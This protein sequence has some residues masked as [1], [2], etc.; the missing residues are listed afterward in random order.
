MAKQKASITKIK[1]RDGRIVK[2]NIKRISNVIF[3]AL[4]S[5]NKKPS[6]V[7]KLSEKIAK[8]VEAKLIKIFGGVNRIPGVEDIQD[9]VEAALLEAKEFD[10][11]KNYIE[12]RQ[13]RREVRE[14]KKELLNKDRLSPLEKR[15]SLNSIRVLASRYLLKNIHGKI[16]EDVPHMFKRVAVA[17]TLPELLYD[18]KVFKKLP[19]NKIFVQKAPAPGDGCNLK[20]TAL[21]KD[22][23]VIKFLESIKPKVRALPTESIE[24]IHS[25]YSIGSF[26]LTYAHLERLAITYDEIK[27][28]TG[29][30]K[31]SF[32]KF[33]DLLSKGYFDKY[34][35]L[36]KKF[37]KLMTSQE[38]MPNSPTLMNAGL[39][40][41]QLSAC[42]VVDIE[43]DIT[44]ILTTNLHIGLIFK[45]GGGVGANY[46]KLRPE[47][48]YVAS[49]GG[50]A[51]GPLSFMRIIDTTTDVIKQGGKRRGANM[52]ILD[53][54]HPDIEKFIMV[55]E[56]LK[57][58]TNFNLSVGMLRE[59]WDAYKKRK[60]LKLVNPHTQ[61]VTRE[62]DPEHIINTIAHSAWKSAEPG[63]LFFDNINKHNV[64]HKAKGEIKA[65]NPCGEQ[66]L[67][68]YESC[69]LG[70]INIARF[71]SEKNGKLTFNYK[72]Y[73]S[74]IKLATHML[75]NIITINK[76]PIPQIR[77]NTLA[78][79]KVGLGI[80][81]LANL[82]YML[83]IPYNSKQ[84]YDLM[85]DL[86][87]SLAYYSMEYSVELA[88]QKGAFPLY[89]KSEYPEG[90]L[91]LS[92]VYEHPKPKRDWQKLTE[93]IKKHGIRNS[94]TTTLAPT[95]SI[96]MISDTSSGLEPQFA[97][98]YKKNVAVGSFY[99]M[100]PVFEQ[101]LICK[102]Q[103][104]NDLKQIVAD[105]AGSIQTLKDYFTE[106]ERKVFVVSQDI[107][108]LDHIIA[109]F[110]WQRWNSSSISKTINMPEETTPQD[111]KQAYIIAHEIGLKGMT[112]FR[113]GSRVGVIEHLG[114]RERFKPQ[115]SFYA[116]EVLE[117]LLKNQKTIYYARKDLQEELYTLL[118][119][120]VTAYQTGE[121]NQIPLISPN[122]EEQ[123]EK[124]SPQDDKHKCPV[125]GGKVVFESGCEKCIECGWSACSV[126]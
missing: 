18:E 121:N 23:E 104:G 55:K 26:P 7:K 49:T 53:V 107:H 1:K 81:G 86:A 97:L 60:L 40:L 28:T 118:K 47:G 123:T 34:F 31:I 37:Y 101:Y 15:F 115:P 12:Y 44:S 90:K 87:E 125:C 103:G 51:S 14:E 21:V 42:F 92:G 98:A 117:A 30:I 76:Y 27:T 105:N 62:I 111:I 119:Q 70:S 16:I 88:K 8:R 94:Y 66:P 17:A 91:P 85:D 25:G 74:T 113:D 64:L 112:I 75:D 124:E 69:N 102:K 89:N 63:V 43:D 10:A 6:Q 73:Y 120:T 11:V 126:S 46:S 109:Q 79:R 96:S 33:L 19:K 122:T 93:D 65:T 95:G 61:K 29:R 56:D 68:P 41:G 45:S 38:F 82:L 116:Q 114:D 52:G 9:L 71:V 48:D 80:M 72:R 106:K 58:F 32:N 100:D 78:S 99:I 54:T 57:S 50:T 5:T 24:E 35:T 36:A 20:E 59:F 67:Y 22:K 2:Y 39:R 3:K 84:A 83:E 108:W 4:A 77:S 110:I 13:N